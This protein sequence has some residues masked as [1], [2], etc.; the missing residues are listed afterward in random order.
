MKKGIL[1]ISFLFLASCSKLEIDPKV[2]AEWQIN[3]FDG[4][5]EIYSKKID[6]TNDLILDV[7][8][9]LTFKYDLSPIRCNVRSYQRI[10]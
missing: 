5:Q 10:K 4:T 1:Y 9:C 2:E 7:N 8:Y 3:Y 6:K